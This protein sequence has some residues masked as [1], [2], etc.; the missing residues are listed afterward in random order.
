MK[1]NNNL[2]VSQLTPEQFESMS[3]EAVSKGVQDVLSRI[4]ELEKRIETARLPAFDR[5]GAAEYCNKSVSWIDRVRKTH[6][7]PHHIVS[8]TPHFMREHLDHILKGGKFDRHGNP[9]IP[10]GNKNTGS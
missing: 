5:E 3:R 2:T 10:A 4:E 1:K 6:R 7:L 8:G 9:V